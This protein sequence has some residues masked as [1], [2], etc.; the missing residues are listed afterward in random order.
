M[1]SASSQINSI[2]DQLNR[3]LLGKTHEVELAL[4]C[5]LAGGHLL[6]EDVPGVGKTTLARSMAACFKAKFTRIQFTSDLLPSDLIGVT[7]YKASKES[8]VFQPGPLFTHVLLADEINRANPKTQ[9]SLLEAMHENQV[10][11]DGKT[12]KLPSPF[13]VIATQNSQDHHGTFPLPEA[14]LDRFLMRLKLGY[15][16]RRNELEVIRGNNEHDFKKFTAHGLDSLK[17]LQKE[18]SD[19]HVADS[20][21]EYI[22]DIVRATRSHEQVMIGVS[23]RGAKALYAACQAYA[24]VKGREY[25]T[26]DD[27]LRLAP[28]VCCHR[29]LMKKQRIISGNQHLAEEV[30]QTILSRIVPPTV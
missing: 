12:Y 18:C 24:M 6:I 26:S 1:N 30:I 23:P 21:V 15:P 29:M 27:V 20:L 9:S 4:T 19:I 22:Y 5:F 7:I 11:H 28:W 8:F 17:T 10:T 2:L 16:N 14:Q 3:S 25:V 13:F